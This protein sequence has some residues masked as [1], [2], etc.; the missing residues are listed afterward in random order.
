MGNLIA[1]CL[2]TKKHEEMVEATISINKKGGYMAKGITAEGN[3]M[4]KILSKVD[5]EKAIN[6]G[7]AKKGY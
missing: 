6:E 5:A 1:Y 3:K 7:I 2:K 4:C